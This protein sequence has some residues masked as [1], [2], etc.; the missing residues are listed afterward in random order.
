MI[1]DR[2]TEQ[3]PLVNPTLGYLVVFAT[4]LG[5]TGAVATAGIKHT[6]LPL[7]LLFMAVYAGWRWL[8]ADDVEVSRRYGR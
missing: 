2:Q 5:V 7:A 3:E 8:F 4:V 6:A 1:T